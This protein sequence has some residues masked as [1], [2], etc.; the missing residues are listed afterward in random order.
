MNPPSKWLG[1]SAGLITSTHLGKR[2]E[3][4]WRRQ[5]VTDADENHDQIEN[6]MTDNIG[7]RILIRSRVIP[8]GS[9]TIDCLPTSFTPDSPA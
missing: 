3:N 6:S 1:D 2:G 7:N 9:V 5:H 4:I 8:F